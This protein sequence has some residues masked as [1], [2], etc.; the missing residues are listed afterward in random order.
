MLKKINFLYI[1]KIFYN[2]FLELKKKEKYKFFIGFGIL[3]A[4]C[5]LSALV[6]VVFR[7]I[8]NTITINDANIWY[9]GMIFLFIIYSLL[10]TINQISN[11]IAWLVVQPVLAKLSENI[12]LK[13]FLH[14]LHMEY[15]FF[16]TKDSKAI[17]SYFETIF[18]TIYQ[19]LSHLIIHIVPS[20]IEMTIVFIFFFYVYG[21]FYS[22]ILLFLL[23][24]FFYFT[25]YS[26]IN[27]KQLD[28]LY[29]DYLD[30]FYRHILQSI[31]QIEVIKTYG[32]YDFEYQKM[33]LILND[34]FSVSIRRTF[35]LDRAQAYQ[36]IAC[37]ITL[38]TISI[39]TFFAMVNKKIS[40]GDFVILNN[41]F[42]QF[43]IPI[44]FLGYIFAELYK[45]FILLKKSFSILNKKED[46]DSLV[47]LFNKKFIP[48]IVFQDIILQFDDER[49]VLDRVSFQLR[50]K[51]KIAIIGSSGSGKSSCLKLIMKLYPLQEGNIF[52]GGQNIH[53]IS[54]QELYK[55]ITIVPQQSYIFA[56]S[57]RENICYNQKNITDQ[58]IMLI[59]KKIK[60]YDKINSLEHGLDTLLESI[61]FSGGERQRISIARALVRNPEIFLFDEITASLDTKT[62]ADIKEYLDEILID[63]TAIFVTHRLLFARDADKI[64]LLKDGRI[65]EMGT[66]EDLIL[67]STEYQKLYNEQCGI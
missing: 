11:I 27:S 19:I 60:L 23:L 29:Y 39:L 43:T 14:T 40:V 67:S 34:F 16:L 57:I 5:M 55:Y 32:G 22:F 4:G 24:I 52:I 31:S 2:A 42:I 12:L 54:N 18:N 48:S 8:V 36:I 33:K 61:D 53:S 13:M 7:K 30:K 3:F 28:I 37:G 56:G 35:Q 66:H 41:Y 26:I 21:Y 9:V 62:E 46:I 38:L 44:T 49:K 63:K 17:N 20:L 1:G 58:E 15:C 59:L 47:F 51:E 6:Q 25:Y 50:P 64:I 65:K 10:W 45:N